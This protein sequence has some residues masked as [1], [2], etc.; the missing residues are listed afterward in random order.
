M[1]IYNEAERIAQEM[2]L[3]SPRKW[4][5]WCKAN[6]KKRHELG[7]PTNPHKAYPNDWKDWS[8]FLRKVN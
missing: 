7:L 2:G 6:P 5:A 8:T 1:I 3:E 4:F